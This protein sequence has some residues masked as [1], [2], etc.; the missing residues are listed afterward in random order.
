MSV[1]LHP[2]FLMALILG[3]IRVYAWMSFAPPF[4]AP[5]VPT[6]A[7]MAM[8]LAVGLAV[9]PKLHLASVPGF[10]MLLGD[11]VVQVAVGAAF[12]LITS[13]V[14]GAVAS[15]GDTLEL[16]GGLALPVAIE[17]IG[18]SATTSLGQ[19][20]GMATLAL[21]V[22]SG[23]DLLLLRGLITTFSFTGPTISSLVPFAHGA[24]SAVA[25]FFTA[26]FEIAGP[27][28]V[29]E[30]A[31]QIGLGLLAKATPQVNIFLF[32]FSVQVFVLVLLLALGVAILP[33]SVHRLVHHVL[34]LEGGLLSG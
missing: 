31:V 34:S 29:V 6:S 1:S 19:L 30:F 24:A 21:L 33:G 25:T 26:I 27:L 3:S 16:F 2:V 28:L 23:G 32:A 11:A 9:A 18:V 20:Y 22:V 7:R 17:P 10:G 15:A 8:S 12:G 4:S 5:Y 13:F 14:I